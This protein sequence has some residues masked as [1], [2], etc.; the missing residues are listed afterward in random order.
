[1]LDVLRDGWYLFWMSSVSFIFV[2]RFMRLIPSPFFD[3]VRYIRT[4]SHVAIFDT[5]RKFVV[6]TTSSVQ[7][8]V[9]QARVERVAVMAAKSTE[10][11]FGLSWPPPLTKRGRGT[12]AA[13][14]VCGCC[15]YRHIDEH[16]SLPAHFTLDV[17]DWWLR[18][19]GSVRTET[20]MEKPH[21]EILG[22]TLGFDVK[23]REVARSLGERFVFR[24]PSN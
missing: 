19:M 16:A 15:V 13:W 2:F 21:A 23:K 9:E 4:C 1:M 5:M 3:D 18:G 12:V 11:T 14:L 22:D 10:K 7:V 20:D 17:L 24:C 6:P 8:D